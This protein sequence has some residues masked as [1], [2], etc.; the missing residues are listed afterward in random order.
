M[1]L[2]VHLETDENIAYIYFFSTIYG[3][4]YTIL[5]TNVVRKISLYFVKGIGCCVH[6]SHMLML[7]H[8]KNQ[9]IFFSIFSAKKKQKIS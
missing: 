9:L 2:R 4:Y 8:W 1:K 6:G 5:W 3:S 7:R